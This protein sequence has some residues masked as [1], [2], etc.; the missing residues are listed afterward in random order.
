VRNI[1]DI[2]QLKKLGIAGALVA[3]ALHEQK[4]TPS[5]LDALNKQ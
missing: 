3:T 4:I 2:Q 5:E 1:H